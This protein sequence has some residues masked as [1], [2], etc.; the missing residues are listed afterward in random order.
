MWGRSEA[1]LLARPR[2]RRYGNAQNIRIIRNSIYAALGTLADTLR[3]D[4]AAPIKGGRGVCARRRAH[5][6]ACVPLC[7]CV[8]ACVR[9]LVQV[10]MGTGQC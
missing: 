1:M 7:P 4:F 6:C 9:A 5:A 10:C 8:H 2:P 3:A